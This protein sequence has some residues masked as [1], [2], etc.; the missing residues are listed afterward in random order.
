[1]VNA[2]YFSGLSASFDQAGVAEI[3]TEAKVALSR[4]YNEFCCGLIKCVG[5]QSYRCQFCYKRLT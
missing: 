5:P 1:M 3:A 4:T 2:H